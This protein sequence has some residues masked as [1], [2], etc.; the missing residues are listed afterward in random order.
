[1]LMIAPR[2]LYIVDNPS[3]NYNGL[4]RNSAYVTGSIEAKLFEA[5]GV[6]NSFTYAA[7][8]GSHCQWRTA[9]TAPL[10][11]NIEKFLLG[12]ASSTTGTFSTDLGGTKP[13][14]DSYMGFTIPT[15][16]GDL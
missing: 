6:K 16:S 13:N 14:P 12:N 7:S 8:S 1:M 11:A 9:Y 2:G 5:L 15:L 3:T 10:V 4:D